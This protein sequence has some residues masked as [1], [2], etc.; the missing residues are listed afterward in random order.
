MVKSPGGVELIDHAGGCETITIAP[1]RGQP[2]PNPSGPLA[3]RAMV[4]MLSAAY[5]GGGYPWLG[6]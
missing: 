3:E 5:D 1:G 2:A 6:P 4:G